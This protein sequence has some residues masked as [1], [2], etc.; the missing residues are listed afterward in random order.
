MIRTLLCMV[1]S[2]QC[3]AGGLVGTKELNQA[4]NRALANGWQPAAQLE[5][6]PLAVVSGDNAPTQSF[7]SSRQPL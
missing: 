6:A 3:S 1:F 4:M 5:Q 7:V 2:T